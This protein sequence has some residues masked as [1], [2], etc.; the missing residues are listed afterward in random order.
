MRSRLI[1][2]YDDL[3]LDIVWGTVK[4]SLLPL[5]EE[6]EKVVSPNQ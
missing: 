2:E 5:I 6:L 4:D 3:D 1:H